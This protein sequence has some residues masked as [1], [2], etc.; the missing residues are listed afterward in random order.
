MLKIIS[1]LFKPESDGDP[2]T[3]IVEFV[4]YVVCGL[5]DKPDDVK[6]STETAEGSMV[7]HVAC[8]K[9]DIGRVIGRRGKTID[10]IR[11]LVQDAGTR[12]ETKV[13]VVVANE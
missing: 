10:S 7:I 13:S 2:K 9:D 12:A 5:V 1:K 6:I 4:R 11:Q 8:A 3:N